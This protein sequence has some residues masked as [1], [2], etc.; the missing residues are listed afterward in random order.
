MFIVL[1]PSFEVVKE[2]GILY[3]I[4]HKNM[5]EEMVPSGL[6]VQFLMLTSGSQQS[7]K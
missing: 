7:R 5:V 4:S 3:K 1:R 2:G 6:Q